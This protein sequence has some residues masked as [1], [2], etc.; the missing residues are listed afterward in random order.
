MGCGRA[1]RY[2][3][4]KKKKMVMRNKIRKIKKDT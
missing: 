2:N 3:K 1:R 4:E